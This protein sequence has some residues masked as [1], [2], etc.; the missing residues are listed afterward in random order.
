M[1]SRTAKCGVLVCWK[2]S[3]R[4]PRRR[5]R[6][7]LEKLGWSEGRNLRINLK[8]AREFGLNVPTTLLVAADEVIEQGILQ[9]KRFD[10]WRPQRVNLHRS[11][12]L[13]LRALCL[14]PL[15]N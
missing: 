10:R 5:I 9:C 12:E 15:P 4:T 7:S 13:A 1:P 14:R 2:V 8:T 11:C 6:E 3:P